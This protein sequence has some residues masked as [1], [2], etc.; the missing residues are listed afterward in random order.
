MTQHITRN[1]YLETRLRVSVDALG[2]CAGA[3]DLAR[4]LLVAVVEAV[5]PVRAVVLDGAGFTGLGLDGGNG[6]PT[7]TFRSFGLKVGAVVGTERTDGVGD[8]LILNEPKYNLDVGF[9]IGSVLIDM[10]CQSNLVGDEVIASN[11]LLVPI[12]IGC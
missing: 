6:R 1:Y 12:M 4:L 7:D 2:R 10:K 11:P 9:F 5:V 3:G 8:L